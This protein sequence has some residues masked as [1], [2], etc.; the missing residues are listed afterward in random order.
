[1]NCQRCN[2][3]LILSIGGKC[4]DTFFANFQDKEYDGYVPDDWNIGGGDYIHIDVCTNCGQI[5]GNFPI[6]PQQRMVTEER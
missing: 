6:K 3:N 2:S 5:Q 4:S 1:M